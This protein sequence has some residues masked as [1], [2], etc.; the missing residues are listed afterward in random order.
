[1][2]KVGDGDPLVIDGDNEQLC[3]SGR[4]DDILQTFAESMRQRLVKR[5]AY[6]AIRDLPAVTL[7]GVS[8][9]LN[10]NAGLLMDVPQIAA[11]PARPASASIAP[12]FRS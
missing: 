4:P 6:A 1:M 10:I 9:D 7:D 11:P 5:E 8:V 2:Q 12:R 3:S